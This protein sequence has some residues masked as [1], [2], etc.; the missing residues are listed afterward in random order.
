MKRYLTFH[1]PHDSDTE[2][3]HTVIGQV[4]CLLSRLLDEETGPETIP[5]A[6]LAAPLLMH[7]TM[8]PPT[9]MQVGV[10]DGDLTT[11]SPPMTRDIDKNHPLSTGAI[12][13]SCTGFLN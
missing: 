13:I 6:D 11:I 1:A 3:I 12:D 5:P 7:L 8:T 9:P 4:H 2:Y 10:I